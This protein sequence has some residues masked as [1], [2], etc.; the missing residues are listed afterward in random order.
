ME[1]LDHT[2]YWLRTQLTLK[3]T[4]HLDVFWLPLCNPALAQQTLFG[5]PEPGKKSS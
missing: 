5:E 2:A 4:I 1:G 3:Q